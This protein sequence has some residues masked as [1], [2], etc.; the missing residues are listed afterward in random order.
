M[1]PATESIR[2]SAVETVH[3]ERTDSTVRIELQ[4]GNVPILSKHLTPAAARRLGDALG[5]ASN[6]LAR[7]GA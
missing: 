1:I 4:V 5:Y 2:I 3:I 7:G 6:D